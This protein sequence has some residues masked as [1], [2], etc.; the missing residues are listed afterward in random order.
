MTNY[1]SI[2]NYG[3]IRNA[4]NVANLPFNH[5]GLITNYP[6]ATIDNEGIISNSGVIINN[7]TINNLGKI[8][9]ENSTLAIG[10]VVNYGLIQGNSPYTV[11]VPTP[12]FNTG[13]LILV[14]VGI[15]IVLVGVYQL[16]RKK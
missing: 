11:S 3:V 16:R 12:H 4:G 5:F 6:G 10:I 8:E 7:G 13:N 2:L 1:G 9:N 14:G 15:A